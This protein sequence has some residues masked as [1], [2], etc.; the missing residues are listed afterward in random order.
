MILL[1][2]W[3]NQSNSVHWVKGK[4]IQEDS[5]A[6]TVQILL[7]DG[8]RLDAQYGN[9]EQELQCGITYDFK[10]TSSKLPFF[11]PRIL[12]AE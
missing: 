4:V 7:D 11:L 9:S 10:L 3:W 1:L 6:N 12:H 2:V 8:T 5:A